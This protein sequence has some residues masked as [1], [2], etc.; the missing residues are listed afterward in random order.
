MKR[1]WFLLII[2]VFG[3]GTIIIGLGAMSVISIHDY[4]FQKEEYKSEFLSLDD[5]QYMDDGKLL[6]RFGD[7]VIKDKIISSQFNVNEIYEIIYVKY[8]YS[9]S[10]E[11]DV[12]KYYE[13]KTLKN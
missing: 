10:H 11:N 2:I 5:V 13:I 1:D 8:S 6:Y 4:I 9:W 12:W 7:I 3:L